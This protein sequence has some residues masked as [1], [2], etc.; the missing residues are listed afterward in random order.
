MISLHTKFEVSVYPLW[1]Y[2]STKCNWGWFRGKGHPR[3]S[4]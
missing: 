1:R 2:E 3:S 4:V